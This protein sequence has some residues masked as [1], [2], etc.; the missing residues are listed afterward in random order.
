MGGSEK[1]ETNEPGK[2]GEDKNYCLGTVNIGSQLH[3]WLGRDK[4]ADSTSKREEAQTKKNSWTSKRSR[5]K[6]LPIGTTEDTC[7]WRQG[8]SGWNRSGAAP[9]AKARGNLS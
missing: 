9:N 5:S 3:F 4:M 8:N 1:G 6:F 2:G 7:H